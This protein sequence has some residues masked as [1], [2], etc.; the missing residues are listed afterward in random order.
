MSIRT[1][2]NIL[3]ILSFILST[4]FAY[5]QIEHG[6]PAPG[7]K[8]I[9][10]I[11]LFEQEQYGSALSIFD[12]IVAHHTRV[13]FNDISSD[14][15]FYAAVSALK[16]NNSDA[17]YRI[18]NFIKRNPESPRIQRACFFM[19]QY[20]YKEKEWEA[21]AYWFARVE[22]YILEKDEQA[23]YYF[24]QAYAYLMIEET[25][26]ANKLFYELLDFPE[27]DYYGPGVY[28]YSHIEYTRG[29]YET[30]LK[31]FKSLVN[32]PTFA[33]LVP[34][35]MAHIYFLQHKFEKVIDY[36]PGIIEKVTPKRKAEMQ[37]MLGNAWFR[38]K[39]YDSTLVYLEKYKA[40][41]TNFQRYDLYQLAYAYYQKG[42]Y[43]NAVKNFEMITN[44][45]DSLS[46][47]ANYHMAASYLKLGD[48]KNAHFAFGN[49]SRMAFD[50]KIKEDALFNYAK[51]TYELSFAPFDETLRIFHSYLEQYKN[52]DR[53]DLIYNYLVDVYMSSKNY[54]AAIESIEKIS[55]QNRQIKNALQ[56]VAYH[57]AIE[58]YNNLKYAEAIQLFDKSLNAG[59]NDAS[60][61][62]LAHYWKGESYFKQEEYSLAIKHYEIFLTTPG[63][64]SSDFYNLTNYNLAYCY[65]KQ[66]N[67]QAAS[68]WFRKYVNNAPADQSKINYDA[69]VRL[70]D[71]YFVQRR[72]EQALTAYKEAAQVPTEKND[73]AI[74][75]QGFS[76][77]I[78]H[79]DQEKIDILTPLTTRE[80][81][82]LADDA[83][84]ESGLAY[85]HLNKIEQSIQQFEQLIEKFPNSNYYKK[86]HLQAGLMYFNLGNNPKAEHHFKQLIENH[87]GTNE[88]S[89]ALVALKNVYLDQNQVDRYFKYAKSHSINISANEQDSLLY[90]SAEKAYLNNDTI[91]SRSLFEEYLERFNDGQFVLK[92]H[93]YLAQILYNKQDYQQAIPHYEYIAAQ[94]QNSFTQTT[95]YNIATIYE[96][97]KNH[98][99]AWE[100][101]N[102]LETIANTNRLL[103]ESRIGQMRA[104]IEMDEYDKINNA[105]SKILITDKVPPEITNE[106]RFA[107]A[108]ALEK[109]ENPK[110]ALTQYRLLAQNPQNKYGARAQY[111]VARIVY[112]QGKTVL[113]ESEVQRFIKKGTPHQ[114]WLGK[115]FLL[116]SKIYEETGKTFQAKAFLQSIIGNYAIE[117]DG[118]VDEAKKRLSELSI[119]GAQKFTKDTSNIELE[120]Q[121]N[122][123]TD[124]PK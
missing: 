7:Q 68:V 114:Y 51:L 86:S 113:A 1:T 41:T 45:H 50:D 80:N 71:S 34:Y 12:D 23:E 79:R 30:A 60:I 40:A 101:Y 27:S 95:L 105:A 97:N 52:S 4:H 6:K 83:L 35:Y 84:F 73:Y 65:F 47:N 39:N 3:L 98:S 31:G 33:P 75:Q 18:I 10:G 24:K 106:A 92:S 89:E 54:K 94:P 121:K 64:Y 122:N 112:E 123:D 91:H 59:G 38:V 55:S 76:A 2:R 88:Y 9:K 78:L 107:K 56:K 115:S 111:E 70:G 87:K 44:K 93:F 119:D 67:Y 72:Y 22:R 15:E 103:L 29:N 43:E 117:D 14:A 104:A 5:G 108:Q 48:K 17:E 62:A 19:G 25:E 58:L 13:G 61:M 16:L 49:A 11:A 8:L 116:L 21:A 32:D 26:K 118:I 81:S 57:H 110:D 85:I 109:L 63:A 102:E 20:K 74:F 99:K 53:S 42:D 100:Y 82:L 36:I 28:Y 120:L 77:G 90:L 46:Q 66:K 37:R 124:T 96:N 69:W